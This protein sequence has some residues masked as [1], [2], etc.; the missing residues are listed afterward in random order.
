[1]RVRSMQQVAIAKLHDFIARPLWDTR[2]MIF[3]G[4]AKSSYKLVPSLGRQASK[5]PE[6]LL[7]FEYVLLLEF[8]RRA[9]PYLKVVPSSDL[10]WTFLAQH[11]GIP[12][13]LLDWTT[14][15]LVAM[16]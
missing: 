8:R 1:M 14:N 7:K 16:Y 10:D 4:V 15:P 11:Y 13:R 5:T 2:T 3:R 6:D 9:L 12:T